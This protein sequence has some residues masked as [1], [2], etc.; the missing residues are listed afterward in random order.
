MNAKNELLNN[1][2]EKEVTS[3]CTDTTCCPPA[4]PFIRTSPKVFVAMAAN[5]KSVVERMFS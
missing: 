3:G 1:K 5:I 2:Q 4:N